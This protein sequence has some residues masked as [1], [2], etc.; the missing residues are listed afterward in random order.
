MV[1]IKP[2]QK[3]FQSFTVKEGKCCS[4]S[5]FLKYNQFYITNPVE[6]EKE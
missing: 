5:T 4:L 3:M 1:Y 2:I 6:R